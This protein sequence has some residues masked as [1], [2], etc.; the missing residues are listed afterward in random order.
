[1]GKETDQHDVETTH[2]LERELRLVGDR[3]VLEAAFNSPPLTS[4]AE[5]DEKTDDLDNRYFDTRDYRLRDKGLAL[6]IRTGNKGNRQTLKAGDGAQTA[7]LSRDEWEIALEQDRPQLA[8]LPDRAKKL[9][10]K[11]VNEDD[12]QTVFKTTFQRRTRRISIDQPGKPA[13]VEA[14][15]DLGVIDDGENAQPIAEIELE[16]LDG[17]PASLYKLAL[18]LQ[19]IVP[20]RL[21]TRSKSNRA[22][23]SLTGEPPAWRRATLPTLMRS[24]N[25]DQA[26]AAI[27]KC[28]FEQ[29]LANQAAAIDGRDVEGVHQM[30]VGLRR[31]RSA[32]SIFK[33]L[34][35]RNQ[36][37]WLQ[38]GARQTANTLG[39]ARDWDVFLDDLLMP[40]ICAQ[41]DDPELLSLSARAKTRRASAYRSARKQLAAKPYNHFLLR[42][43]QWLEQ[44]DWRSARSK[45]Q[46]ALGA[47]SITD[48][49]ASLLNARRDAALRL[50]QGF[51][52]MPAVERHQL[53]IALKKLRYAVEFFAPLFEKRNVKSFVGSLKA[54]QD[55]LGHLNDVTVAE[56]LL[57]SILS[58]PGKTDIRRP[59][60]M[61]I[62]WHAR[63][64]FDL[65]PRLIRDWS[66]FAKREPFW[67]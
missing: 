66:A 47:T 32:L 43:G 21:E 22:F 64:V 44:Q 50:G 59:A 58:R 26:M 33:P 2:P 14:M 16:L 24:S 67:T 4:K 52:D 29:W 25:V 1:M 60:G 8:A 12:L 23:D 30:R 41:P 42:F 61:V 27:F 38:T 3:D 40:I 17:T 7:I 62:G 13:T 19:E 55:D 51:A 34:I 11:G 35:P 15:I 45:K 28:C 49:A 56:E 10:P 46:A 6:R 37:A 53:R 36:R 20:L 65:E 5:G 9:I 57:D 31:L 18:E 48:F 39:P 54:L 63:G